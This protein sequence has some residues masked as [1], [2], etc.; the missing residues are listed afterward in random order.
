MNTVH[1][2][3]GFVK[4]EKTNLREDNMKKLSVLNVLAVLLLTVLAI[5]TGGCGPI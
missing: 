3:A 4:K 1:N 5:V 2:F